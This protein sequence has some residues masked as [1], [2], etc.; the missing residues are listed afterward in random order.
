M[1]LER[2]IALGTSSQELDRRIDLLGLDVHTTILLPEPFGTVL[3]TVL[4]ATASR[5]PA[6]GDLSL[7][8]SDGMKWLQVIDRIRWSR[9][10]GGIEMS[11]LVGTGTIWNEVWKHRTAGLG[12]VTNV[13]T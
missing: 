8:Q 9:S 1:L 10:A 3:E 5:P 6:H 11:N 7:H 13:P 12:Y 2:A 4:I